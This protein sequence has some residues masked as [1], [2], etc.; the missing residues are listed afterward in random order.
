MAG[1]GE[2]ESRNPKPGCI[3]ERGRVPAL[4]QHPGSIA[5][6]H[7]A[8][9]VEVR[10]SGQVRPEGTLIIWSHAY[11]RMR[12]PEAIYHM[13]PCVRKHCAGTYNYQLARPIALLGKS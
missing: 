7:Q 2:K 13:E 12:T 8:G 10:R 4:L 3:T 9:W 5:V 11:E 1:H 6:R